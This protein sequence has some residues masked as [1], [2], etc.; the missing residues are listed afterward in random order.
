MATSG[1]N[2]RN[3]IK[4]NNLLAEANG[5]MEYHLPEEAIPFYTKALNLDPTNT[6][7]WIDLG[8]ASYLVKA[9]QRALE[10]FE[11]AIQLDPNLAEAWH[12]KGNVLVK[13]GRYPEAFAAFVVTLEKNPRHPVPVWADMGMAH[14]A[15]MEYDKAIT[16][17][18]EA[19]RIHP[20]HQEVLVGKGLALC[21]QGY[22]KE[23]MQCFDQALE[24]NPI[25]TRARVYRKVAQDRI[26]QH[27][28]FTQRRIKDF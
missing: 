2:T 6:A 21:H 18:D 13:L 15:L 12:K 9:Y 8:T 16:C 1:T 11:T 28:G 17:F 26:D 7:V 4:I 22:F 27:G 25:H 24:V 23:A 3:Q 19:L 20:L 5:R 14:Y 10:C